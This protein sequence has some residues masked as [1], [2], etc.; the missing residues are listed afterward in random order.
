MSWS[1]YNEV[2]PLHN[3]HFRKA[4]ELKSEQVEP[5]EVARIKTSGIVKQLNRILINALG[6]DHRHLYEADVDIDPRHEAFWFVGGIDPSAKIMSLRQEHP[7]FKRFRRDPCN[8]PVQYLGNPLMALRHQHP[9]E[10]FED[11]RNFENFTE[12]NERIPPVTIDPRAHG[13]MTDYRHGTC[14]PGFWP[15]NVREYGLISYQ[16]RTFMNHEKY[17]HLPADD[18]QNI[19]HSSGIATSYAWL[20]AQA[21]YQGFTTYNELTYSLATQTVLTDGQHWSFYKYQLNTT[22]M[23]VK[24]DAPNYR[25]NKCWGTKEMKLYDQIDDNGKIHGLNDDVLK[26]LIQFYTNQPKQRDHEMK[27]YLD[28]KVKKIAD[29]DDVKQRAW[30]EKQFKYLMS[31]RPRHRPVPEIY[32]WEKIYKID[33]DTRPLDKK[34]RFF[35]LGI[36]P[37]KRLFKDHQPEYIPRDLKARGPHDLKKWENTYYPHDHRTNMP[38]ALSWSMMG[39]PRY[40][41]AAKMDRKRKSYK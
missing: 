34:R 23:H 36:N 17:K 8:R 31:N 29:L 5:E 18:R 21:Y 13:F 27:P 38:R 12:Y 33:N 30:L 26:I 39:A 40:K 10:P 22:D 24:P 25:F 15:G 41:F 19:L 1:S 2:Y 14:I 28:E 3:F 32:S 9:L 20:L 37:F 7:F 4:F 6:A 11:V 16:D 35:E